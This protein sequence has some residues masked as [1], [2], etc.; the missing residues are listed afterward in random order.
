MS[1]FQDDVLKF[2]GDRVKE[3]RLEV[4]ERMLKQIKAELIMA[5]AIIAAK[6]FL[7]STKVDIGKSE[8]V[9][10]LL[11]ESV[12]G[13]MAR[14]GNEMPVAPQVISD[15]TLPKG[16][17]QGQLEIALESVSQMERA[18]ASSSL[19]KFFNLSFAGAST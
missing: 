6:K 2:Y 8:W 7:A 18:R 17:S 9:Y 4:L 14:L 10:K 13:I 5:S 12:R 3:N 15:I 11:L 1:S 19:N 16:R